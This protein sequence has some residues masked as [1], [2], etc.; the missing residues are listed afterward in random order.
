MAKLDKGVILPPLLDKKGER[1]STET[2]K[3]LFSAVLRAIDENEAADT[4]QKKWSRFGYAKQLMTNVELSMKSRDNALAV[5]RAGINWVHDNF[6]FNTGDGEP[7]KISQAMRE[8]KGS[9]STGIIEG[10]KDR[11]APGEFVLRVPYEG[12]VLEGDDLLIQIEKWVR[13]GVIEMDC[14]NAI[15]TVVRTKRW[16]D[17]SD[18]FFVL[19]G[20]SSA[21]GP[22]LVLLQLGANI[23]GVDICPSAFGMPEG[24]Y[25]EARNLK[26]PKGGRR[27]WWGPWAGPMPDGR[28]GLFAAVQDSC[29]KL[30][31]PLP[32]D[33][34]SNLSLSQQAHQAGCDLLTQTPQIKN[35]LVDLCKKEAKNKQVV[36]GAYAYL[37]GVRFVRISVAMDAIIQ[38]MID[39]LPADQLALAYLCTPTD[40]H[41]V[42]AGAKA[43]IRSNKARAPFWQT[44][45]GFLPKM[46]RPN[47]VK[48][49]PQEDGSTLHAVDAIVLDQGPNYITAKRLQHWRAVVAREDDKVIVSSNVA[50]STATASVTSNKLFALAY[51][52]LHQF[53]P[54]EVFQQETSNAV[55]ASLLLYDL[56]SPDTAAHPNTQLANPLQL[57]SYNGFHGGAWRCGS[58]FTSIGAPAILVALVNLVVQKYLTVYNATQAAG[59]LYMLV[60]LSQAYSAGAQDVWSHIGETLYFIQN[61]ALLEVVHSLVGAVRAGA[62]TT[63]LQIASRVFVVALVKWISALHTNPALYIIGA[64]WGVTEVVRYSWYALNTLNINIKPLT[65]LRYSTF[66]PLYPIGVYGELALAYASMPMLQAALETP[67]PDFI[68]KVVIPVAQTLDMDLATLFMWALFPAYAVGLPFLYSHMLA[69]RNRAMQRLRPVKSKRD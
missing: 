8:G 56:Q 61:L 40:I 1:S 69:A 32:Q 21:M 25:D 33:Q 5:A 67:A 9:F 57:F 49:V 16:L 13:N 53:K 18:R 19:L 26:K 65:W 39:A 28:R 42:P 11:P 66:L 38:G 60:L 14:G 6:E 30:Y 7:V 54:M 29:G 36:I 15:A 3:A 12:K 47:R 50:P 37:D 22:L 17:L 51:T 20:A 41:L 2:G 55:M 44:I 46:N 34:K 52:Q 58:A 31:F 24:N 45:T 43:A 68:A 62:F 23:I 48:S 10:Q 59:W 4:A 27:D 64:A 63:L 35:W